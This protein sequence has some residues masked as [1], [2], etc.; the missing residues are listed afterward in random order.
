MT[1]NTIRD[2]IAIPVYPSM[3]IVEFISFAIY[4]KPIHFLKNNGIGELF[5]IF[6]VSFSS[7]LNSFSQ[8]VA[9]YYPTS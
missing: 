6:L 2:V 4:S 9:I 3:E 1:I 8:L 7:L 5:I